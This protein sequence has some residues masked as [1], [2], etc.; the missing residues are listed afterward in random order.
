M[1]EP[2]TVGPGKELLAADEPTWM[3]AARTQT[4][5]RPGG[6]CLGVVRPVTRSAPSTRGSL[7]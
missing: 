5:L 1:D 7:D 2:P 6:S 4:D 3:Y